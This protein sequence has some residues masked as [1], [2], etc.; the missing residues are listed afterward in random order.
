MKKRD[1]NLLDNFN[2]RV[3]CE[4]FLLY[5]LGRL[6]DED[7]ASLDDEE[8][9]RVI[10]EG[11]REHVE[12]RLD[13]RAELAMGLRAAGARPLRM[14]HVVE[15][16][17]AP[18]SSLAPIVQSY[19]AYLFRRLEEC[20]GKAADLVGPIADRLFDSLDDRVAAEAALDALGSIRSPVSARV[21]AH[22]VS[23]PML[24]EDLEKKAYALVRAMWPLPR[25]Y[26]AY[27]LKP[28]THE[29][30]P[31]RWFQLMIDCDEPSAV[32]RI[33]E[34]VLAHAEN[35]DFH[36]DLQALIGLLGQSR[37]PRT[38]EKIMEVLNHPDTPEAAAELLERFLKTASSS[39]RPGGGAGTNSRT[40]LDRLHAAN[41]KYLAA[42]KLLD[43]ARKADSLRKL[44]ELLNE[45]PGYPFALMLKQWISAS[46]QS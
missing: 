27:S 38:E 35:P 43:S 40:T 16:I 26:I 31:F 25:H 18:L 4:D 30:L 13:V 17:E 23:E 5:E 9:R 12:T 3:E 10:D 7:R 44:D 45:E 21:L 15:D 11:I 46:A 22:V 32:D 14:V 24:E 33:L 8:F 19:T 29:D 42:A 36:E 39:A 41:K 6:I 37:D 34:E 28:H 2:Y 20:S 1:N